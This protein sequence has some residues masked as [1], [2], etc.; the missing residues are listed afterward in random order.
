MFGVTVNVGSIKKQKFASL[1]IGV[2]EV[3]VK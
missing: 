1:N 2:T 3:Q